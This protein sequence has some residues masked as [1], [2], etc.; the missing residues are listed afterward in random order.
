MGAGEV[1]HVLAGQ[2]GR[3]VDAIH[4]LLRRGGTATGDRRRRL[5]EVLPRLA[6]NH[7]G[8]LDDPVAERGSEAGGELAE[9]VDLVDQ[10]P[11]GDHRHVRDVLHELRRR[12]RLVEHVGRAGLDE[13]AG[14]QPCLGRRDLRIEE[15]LH[16]RP[17][18]AVLRTGRLLRLLHV[19][20]ELLDQQRQLLV[21]GGQRRRPLLRRLKLDG[22]RHRLGLLGGREILR[23]VGE[24]VLLGP[25]PVGHR[26]DAE[27]L[28]DHHLAGL[29]R[30]TRRRARRLGVGDEQVEGRLRVGGPRLRQ[31]AVLERRAVWEIVEVLV[32]P[33]DLLLAHQLLVE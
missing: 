17:R 8:V 22:Q 26:G 10:P 28:F 15:P 3:A 33:L 1:P 2:L 32:S 9:I 7:L 11:G 13:V 31:L 29:Q 25:H 18:R 20:R 12:S 30:E 19:G 24:D 4:H 6:E 16:R 23:L 5:V 14:L 21:V 27:V